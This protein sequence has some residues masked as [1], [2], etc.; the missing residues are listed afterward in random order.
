MLSPAVYFCLSHL[1]QFLGTSCRVFSW[2]P[3]LTDV[4]SLSSNMSEPFLCGFLVPPVLDFCLQLKPEASLF[5]RYCR[6]SI[7]FLA[8]V[9]SMSLW[10]HRVQWFTKTTSRRYVVAF[11]PSS[12]HFA[13]GSVFPNFFLLKAF[14]MPS[15]LGT[16]SSAIGTHLMAAMSGLSVVVI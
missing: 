15:F 3:S 9:R 14:W 10:K 13:A 8:F 5:D 2:E 11:R 1:W 4:L 7:T 16:V 12:W 6:S